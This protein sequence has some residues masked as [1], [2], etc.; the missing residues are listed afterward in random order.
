MSDDIQGIVS[1]IREMAPKRHSLIP[2]VLHIVE[3]AADVIEAQE[4]KIKALEKA[5]K[6]AADDDLEKRQGG[7]SADPE[8]PWEFITDEMVERF[9]ADHCHMSSFHMMGEAYLMIRRAIEGRIVVSR[10]F[11]R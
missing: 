5:L 7:I 8:N 10:S 11:Q 3:V 1:D 4:A 2:N 6:D 9:D